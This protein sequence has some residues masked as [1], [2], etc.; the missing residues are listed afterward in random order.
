MAQ[1]IPHITPDWESLHRLVPSHYP[2]IQ[3][4]ES[5]V[6]PDELDI[7][8]AI[9]SLTNERLLDETG[10][11][12]LVPADERISGPG[13]SPVMAAFTHIDT[14]SRFTDGSF[15]VYYGARDIDTALAET[16][17]HREIFLSA[18]EEPDTEITM[19]E[20]V[21]KVALPMLDIRANSFQNLH[22]PNSYVASQ[23]FAIQKREEGCNGLVYNSVRHAAGECIAAFK[24]KAVTIPRQGRHYRYVWNGKQQRITDYFVVSD[25][26]KR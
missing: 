7:A 6:E 10:N 17:H 16:M 1:K 18:T 25:A 20:Y 12:S 13:S 2:P 26:K 21:G 22:E 11:L 8:F 4:F 23:N 24:P 14:P 19:R 15:G 9:E 5:V 3:L